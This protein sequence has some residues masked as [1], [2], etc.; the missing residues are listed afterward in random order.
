M[1]TMRCERHGFFTLKSTLAS[2]LSF[3]GL[4]CSLISYEGL[5]VFSMISLIMSSS[6]TRMSTMS[7]LCSSFT[8][9]KKC[10]TISC[11]GKHMSAITAFKSFLTSSKKNLGMAISFTT[12]TGA[13]VVFEIV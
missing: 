4:F 11:F 8:F 2:M 5:V 7:S 6:S 13:V 10:F 9:F 12:E 1:L 3:R